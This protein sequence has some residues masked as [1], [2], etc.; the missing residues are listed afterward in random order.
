MSYA[1][2]IGRLRRHAYVAWLLLGGCAG[3]SNG[4]KP[5]LDYIGRS[6]TT[7][8]RTHKD[9]VHAAE[10]P[11]LGHGAPWTV[12]V[13]ADDLEAAR[14]AVQAVLSEQAQG[15]VV[16]KALPAD[17]KVEEP[18]LLYVPNPYVVPGGRFNEMYAWDSYFILLGLIRDGHVET[19]RG[20]VDNF[21]YEITHYG[22]LLNANRTYYLTR[23]QPPFLSRMVLEVFAK[24][25]DTKWLASTVPALAAYHDYWTREPHGLTNGLSRYYD[26]GAGPAPEVLTGELENGLTHYDRVREF[27]RTQGDKVDG[28]PL[29]EM[30]DAAHDTL[31]PAFYVGDRSMRESGFDPSGRFGSFNV[32]VTHY[33]PVCL[34]TLLQVMESDMADILARLGD[35]SAGV[36][37]D[38]AASRQAAINKTL[39]NAN[40]GL[41]AD[42]DISTGAHRDYP[43]ATT[44]MPLWAGIASKEQ[45][46]EVVR[47]LHLFEKPGGIV[48]STRTTGV[49]W[50]APFGWAPLQIMA[51]EGL[52]RYGYNAEAD[53]ISVAFL[54]LVLQEFRE[55]DVIF[56]KYD[57]EA[58]DS[59]VA[60]NVHFGYSTNVIGFGWTNAT[61]TRLW[62]AL[63]KRA[64][65]EVVERA[66]D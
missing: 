41:Y 29:G 16:L 62:D 28:Y 33:V 63:P 66:G 54:S 27:Y 24:T 48:T 5:I 17:L 32:G 30:Y 64:R 6:W 1:S 20:M 65:Q 25:G 50:D 49:Q 51:V 39:W 11:K 15:E 21:V 56:E 14:K 35:A 52:R 43:F 59:A 34:N 23:S 42:A 22:T 12:Y 9:I 7:L 8:E 13:P 47:N 31:L 18:G 19:A 36:W 10:D 3:T 26:L 40:S 37:R 60:A 4:A 55:H 61:W 38:R 2:L 58:R 46:A 45:A 44:F 57:V 53:R